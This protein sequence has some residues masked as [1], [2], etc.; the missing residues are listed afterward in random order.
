MG[1]PATTSSP[2]LRN[3]LIIVLAGL[4]AYG[5]L[6]E[7]HD[8]RRAVLLDGPMVQF[9]RPDELVITWSLKPPDVLPLVR[10]SLPEERPG[11]V[12]ESREAGQAGAAFS[13]LPAGARGRY[14]LHHRGLLS[15]LFSDTLAGPYEVAT[16]PPPGTPFRFLAFGDSGDGGHT[17]EELGRVM[18]SARPDLIIH[19]GDLVYPS[20]SLRDYRANFFEPYAGLIRSIPFMPC[21]GNHDVATEQGRPLLEVFTLPRNGPPGIEPERNYWFDFGDARFVALDSNPPE[22]GGRVTNEE[23]RRVVA[24]W[25]QRVLADGGPRWKFVYFHHP[26]YTGSEHPESGGSHMKEAFVRV[27]E[28]AGVDVVFC[29][30]NHLY[31]RTAPI[32]GDRVVGDGQGVV[33][34]TTGAGGV[35]RYPEM[36]PPPAYMRAFN[37]EV[38]SFTRVDL[39]ADRLELRQVDENNQVIDEYILSKPPGGA[40]A[41]PSVKASPGKA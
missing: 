38:F 18:S 34:I 33:Y 27:F 16:P 17:Q 25:V 6:R 30:H 11:G 15:L 2:A 5:C 22:E 12:S 40:A 39:V 3:T 37:A 36:Q 32:R 10:L 24:P 7:F 41:G 28:D 19:V 4:L 29:G 31:E 35:S 14:S 21:L 26:F 1:K 20:G 9:P 13:G 8:R 23:R